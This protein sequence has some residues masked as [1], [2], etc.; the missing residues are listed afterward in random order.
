MSLLRLVDEAR[1]CRV[2]ALPHGPRP[3][4]RAHPDARVVMVG[5]APGAKVHASGVPWDDASGAHLREWL[6]VDRETFDRDAFAI[7][8]MS[9]CWPGRR[10]GG[11]LPPR[12]ECAPL[13]QQ[14]FLDA[15]PRRE[16]TILVGGYAVK[17]HLGVPLEDAV[18]GFRGLLPARVAV[19]H[20]AWRSRL[21]RAKNPW[22]DDELL[23]ALRARVRAVLDG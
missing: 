9:F 18:R 20:P 23:P 13:W 7:L 16:L 4:F 6:D 14:R 22:F 1:A 2:C 17:A 11:D 5:Q 19:P 10:A 21:W 15:L 3:V 8:P 12:E